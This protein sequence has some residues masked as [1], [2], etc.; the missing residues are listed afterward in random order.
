MKQSINAVVVIRQLPGHRPV[1]SAVITPDASKLMEGRDEVSEHDVRRQ[2]EYLVNEHIEEFK[3][4]FV[5]FK[6]AEW[7]TDYVII[8]V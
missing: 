1:T 4:K 7:H 5:E 8:N 3:N 6:N 2:L